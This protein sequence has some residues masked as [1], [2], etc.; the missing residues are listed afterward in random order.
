M[1]T[2]R[3]KSVALAL[4]TTPVDP[5]DPCLDG[6]G[7]VANASSPAVP[8][9]WF[10]DSRLA[11]TRTWAR[12]NHAAPA[13]PL[14][15]SVI[16][17]SK[18][19]DTLV[20]TEI[21]PINVVSQDVGHQ[22]RVRYT[23]PPACGGGSVSKVFVGIDLS[24][25]N[26]R[27]LNLEDK[28]LRNPFPRQLSQSSPDDYELYLYSPEKTYTFDLAVKWQLSG[29]EQ[30]EVLDND[31]D[32]FSV[33]SPNG[34]TSMVPASISTPVAWIANTDPQ[35]LPRNPFGVDHPKASVPPSP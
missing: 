13:S 7:W 23:T 28:A 22:A 3:D 30:T 12:E 1:V 27:T 4:K 17:T 21:T 24:S 31:G 2:A 9:D 32:H 25:P 8:A 14:R 34:A 20:V 29:K 26:Y 10:D 18:T 6:N 11:K 19:T 35:G 33:S 5:L 16:A 15:L